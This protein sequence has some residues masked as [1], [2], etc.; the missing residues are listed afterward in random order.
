MAED[1]ARYEWLP[2][3]SADERYPMQVLVG[4]LRC[5]GD[6]VEVPAGKII[7]KGWGELGSRRIVGSRLKPVPE[8]LSLAWFSY[9]EDMFFAGE[10]ELPHAELLELFRA[11]FRAPESREP[12]R[13]DKILVGMGLGGWVSVWLAGRGL[14]REVACASFEPT[15]REWSEVLDNPDVPRPSFVTS[16]LRARLSDAAWRSYREKGPPVSRWPRYARPLRWG[17]A[18]GGIQVPLHVYVRCFNGERS[19]Y[20]FAR[21]PPDEL[22]RAPKRLDITWQGR[23][24]RKLLS[25]ITLDEDE[26]FEALEALG[27]AAPEG[28][29][30]QLRVAYQPRSRVELVLEGDGERRTLSRAHVELN[31]LAQV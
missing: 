17:L 18:A 11:G 8:Q 13:W 31:S 15:E 5:G 12:A 19:W 2:S 24:G 6:I 3:E 25:R 4:R 20:D 1:I 23:K 14:V 16:T 28:P 26:I 9:T 29:V 21:W 22:R 10:L 27:A 30:P 7:N